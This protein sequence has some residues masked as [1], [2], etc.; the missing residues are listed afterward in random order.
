MGLFKKYL[1]TKP[2]CEVTFFIEPEVAK[3]AKKAALVGEFNNWNIKNP[4]WLNPNRDGSFKGTI[5][6]PIDSKHQFRYLLDDHIWE[7]DH[8]ADDYV[9]IGFSFEENSVVI[10]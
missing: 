10:V 5:H 3:G 7:N 6:L 4:I 9:P 1:E 8:Y 2:V